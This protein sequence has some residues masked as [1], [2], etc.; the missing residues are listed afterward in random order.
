MRLLYVLYVMYGVFCIQYVM[1]FEE[2]RG[3]RE[4]RDNIGEE[5]KKVPVVTYNPYNGMKS[6]T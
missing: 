4:K 1:H 3:E 5:L 6:T 2:E